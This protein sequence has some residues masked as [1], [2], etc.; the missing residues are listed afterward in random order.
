MAPNPNTLPRRPWS[1]IKLQLAAVADHTLEVEPQGGQHRFRNG[2]HLLRHVVL[3][4]ERVAYVVE[5]FGAGRRH[6]IADQPTRSPA[7]LARSSHVRRRGCG[8][9]AGILAQVLAIYQ[10]CVQLAVSYF[11]HDVSEILVDGS[12][13]EQALVELA[14]HLL[15]KRRPVA[16]HDFHADELDVAR[17]RVA[18]RVRVCI[19]EQPRIAL[20]RAARAV[21]GAREKQFQIQLFELELQAAGNTPSLAD[22]TAEI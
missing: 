2:F 3:T 15:C 1:S 8:V 18:I 20:A 16:A 10:R 11:L 13:G 5:R 6:D 9:L 4:I 22:M 7:G 17:T 21:P 14:L 12:V 19:A